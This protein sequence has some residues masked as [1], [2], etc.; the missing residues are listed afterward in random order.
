MSIRD[1]TPYPEKPESRISVFLSS[2][3]ASIVRREID[4]IYSF[5]FI[6]F[7]SS[8]PERPDSLLESLGPAHDRTGGGDTE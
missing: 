1:N 7:L 3:N 2:S 6:L 8:L 4:F 5:V